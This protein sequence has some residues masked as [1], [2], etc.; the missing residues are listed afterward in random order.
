MGWDSPATWTLV[1]DLSDINTANPT[2]ILTHGWHD[3]F[4]SG[5][6]DP[7]P[8]ITSFIST[9]A[10]NFYL[11]QQNTGSNVLANYNILAVDWSDESNWNAGSDPGNTS[12]PTIA[13]ELKS[14]T[15]VSDAVQSAVNGIAAGA[16]LGVLLAAAAFD[17]T[18]L[19]LIGHSNGAG[20]MASLAITLYAK[21]HQKVDELVVLDAPVQTPSYSEVKAAAPYV[22]HLS[23]YYVPV[24]PSTDD[25]LAGFLIS[26]DGS[27]RLDAPFGFG[28]AI[29]GDPTTT[30]IDN[31]ELNWLNEDSGPTGHNNIVGRYAQTADVSS[32][33]WGFAL[34]SFGISQLGNATSLGTRFWVE[35]PVGQFQLINPVVATALEGFVQPLATISATWL[36]NTAD[37]GFVTTAGVVSAVYTF[38]ADGTIAVSNDVINTAQIATENFEQ[39]ANGVWNYLS[40]GAATLWNTFNATIQSATNA[41][42]QL[43]FIPAVANSPVIASTQVDI[44]SDAALINFDLTVDNIGNNDTLLVAIGSQVIGQISLAAQQLQNGSPVE[45]WVGDFAGQTDQTLTFYM[46]SDVKSDA[47]F[48]IGNPQF[49]SITPNDAAASPSFSNLSVS[50][51]ITYGTTS[52]DFRATL[53]LAHSSHPTPKALR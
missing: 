7:Y 15:L 1:T 2:I 11:G 37:I 18:K 12:N 32:S 31:Y 26:S 40:G 38:G 17:P 33:T 24:V 27:L 6:S 16:E 28:A 47:I 53:P 3:G 39:A 44:P 52:A 9:F 4:E 10:H 22:Q 23:N 13:T 45:F 41:A 43:L 29:A 5:P 51:S 19:M 34:S 21:V 35:G 30:S 46:P 42:G 36:V 50:S 49:T 8:Q 14:G 48:T 25:Q 20:F